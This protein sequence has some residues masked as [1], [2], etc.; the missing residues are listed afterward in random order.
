LTFGSRGA[1]TTSTDDVDAELG[2]GPCRVCALVDVRFEACTVP[3]CEVVAE[4]LEPASAEAI[5]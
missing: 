3:V 2:A 4:S 5:P 1:E